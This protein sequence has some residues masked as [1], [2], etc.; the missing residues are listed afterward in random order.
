LL[1]Q[2]KLI[3]INQQHMRHHKMIIKTACSNQLQ[4]HVTWCI[5]A[6]CRQHQ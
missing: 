4:Q 2:H 5:V 1:I 3:F 6:A